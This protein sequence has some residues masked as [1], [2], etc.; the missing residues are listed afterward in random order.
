LRAETGFP[1]RRPGCASRE[2]VA[3]ILLPARASGRNESTGCQ[4]LPSRERR[5]TVAVVGLWR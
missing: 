1:L 4:G 3:P 5:G 2:L